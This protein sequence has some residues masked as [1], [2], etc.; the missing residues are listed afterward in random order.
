MRVFIAF[1][2]LYVA[3]DCNYHAIVVY[4][5]M[6]AGW[7]TFGGNNAGRLKIVKLSMPPYYKA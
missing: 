4:V 7:I 3:I 1:V 5:N 6:V 2:R